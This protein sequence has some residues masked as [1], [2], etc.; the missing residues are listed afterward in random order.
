[1]AAILEELPL[2]ELL[3]SLLGDDWRRRLENRSK[4]NSQAL[5]EYFDLVASSKSAKWDYETRRLLNQFHEF[6]GEY[7]PTIGLFTKFFQRYLKLSLST[8][9]RYYYV[10]SAF[11]NWYSGQKLP[12]KV[13]AP[14][15]L[16]QHVPDEDVEKLLVVIQGKKSHKCTIDRDILLVET[17]YHT[18]L[19]RSELS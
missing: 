16:P 19:R 4:T 3:I 7:P 2:R 14:K 12:F 13:K 9:A 18:G 6:I 8:K 11:F 15:P 10:F 1:M 5:T 17:A